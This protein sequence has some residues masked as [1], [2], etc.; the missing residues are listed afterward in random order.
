VNKQQLK[1]VLSTNNEIRNDKTKLNNKK[2]SDETYYT[3][4]NKIS[5][6]FFSFSKVKF[7]VL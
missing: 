6:F 1:I 3:R 4:D 7:K 2:K 5:I